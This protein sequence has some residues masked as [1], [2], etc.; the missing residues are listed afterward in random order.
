[1]RASAS[2][3][4]SDGRN[5]TRP[6]SSTV[7]AVVV[8]RTL[9]IVSLSLAVPLTVVRLL[10]L[11][12]GFPLVP[13]MTVF[14]YVVLLAAI[15]AVAAVAA[16]LRPQAWIGGV[17]LVVGLALLAPRV[18]AGPGPQEAPAGPELTVAVANLRVGQGDA[19]QVVTN[20]DTHDVDV[21]VVLELTGDAVERLAAAGLRDRLPNATLEPSRRTSGG[22]IYSH[23]PLEDRAPSTQRGFG[24]TPRAV[25]TVADG[26]QV[27]LDAVHPL[28]P[29]NRGWVPRWEAALSSLPDPADPDGEGPTRVLAG[30]FNATHDHRMFRALLRRG[31]VDAADAV[32]AGLRATFNGLGQGDPVPP[33]AIDHVLV[34]RRVAVEDVAVEPLPGS[35]H[36]Q[37]VVSLRLPAG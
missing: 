30:D 22:G 29:V 2:S 9:V 18:L 31:W 33:V 26:V 35:D 5:G 15:A 4:A 25:L 24:R 1:M 16:R 37:L 19:D 36:R 23:L 7:P 6:R 8:V 14:P 17:T 20:V 28:P 32:G 13:L 11:D 12:R 21:L 3:D 34:D 10:G 27:E